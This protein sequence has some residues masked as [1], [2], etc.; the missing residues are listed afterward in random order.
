M[1]SYYLFLLLIIIFFG[2]QS[3]PDEEDCKI[4]ALNII[5]DND[6]Y[7]YYDISN[8]KKINAVEGTDT[9]NGQMFYDVESTMKITILDECIWY[10]ELGLK[11]I[12]PSRNFFK[13]ELNQS[14]EQFE[15]RKTFRFYKTENGWRGED[16]IIY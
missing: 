2:C 8:L 10:P 4:V 1:K 12:P 5:L 15:F 6:S 9:K 3:K 11:V 14:G 13:R 16:N 7:R